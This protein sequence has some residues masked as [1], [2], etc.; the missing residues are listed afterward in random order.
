VSGWLTEHVGRLL[1][2]GDR[3][4]TADGWSLTVLSVDGRRAGE[5]EVRAPGASPATSS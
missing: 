2:A 3:W 5:V 4:T 1:A